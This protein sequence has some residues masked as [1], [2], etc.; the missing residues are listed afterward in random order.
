MVTRAPSAILLSVHARRENVA[1]IAWREAKRL[2]FPAPSTATASTRPPAQT[3]AAATGSWSEPPAIG[4]AK[5]QRRLSFRRT[6]FH[7][8]GL[9]LGKPLFRP[10]SLQSC[11]DVRIQN[12][13][14]DGPRRAVLSSRKGAWMHSRVQ[15]RDPPLPAG[16]RNFEFPDHARFYG[17]RRRLVHARDKDNALV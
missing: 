1:A 3:I 15:L 12:V 16:L 13:A 2:S 10:A 17:P 14:K 9:R 7:A 4:T 5:R 6:A 8:S 11:T